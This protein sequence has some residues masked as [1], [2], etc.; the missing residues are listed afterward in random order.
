M[1]GRQAM[2]KKSLRRNL[3][4]GI[5]IV[6]VMTSGIAGYLA[7]DWA[8]DEAIEMQDSIL[9]HISAIVKT[10]QEESVVIT[11]L[12]GVDTDNH[13]ILVRQ[14][15]DGNEIA[16][17]SLWSLP[18]GLQDTTI[19]GTVYRAFLSEMASGSR[20]A[21]LQQIAVRDEIG[22]G[23]AIRTI[24]PILALIPLIIIMTAF[25]LSSSFKILVQLG[26]DLDSRS[27]DNLENLPLVSA[28]SELQ[29]FLTSLNRMFQRAHSSM[30]R[31]KK[32]IGDAAHELR[33]PITALSIQAENLD[34]VDLPA[35]TRQRVQ[36]VKAGAQ[37]TKHLL[38]QLLSMARQESGIALNKEIEIGEATKK[39]ISNLI[40]SA[41]RKEIDLGLEQSEPLVIRA[42][43]ISIEMLLRNVID[44][45]IKYTPKG[46][47]IDI[48]LSRIDEWAAISVTD[49]GPGIPE[50]EIDAVFSPFV[51]G[52]RNDADGAG[53]GL[54]IVQR[55][56]NQLNGRVQLQNRTS[57]EGLIVSIFLP[58]QP[59]PRA[60]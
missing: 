44:N 45:A 48:R 3:F 50:N 31:Q 1:D 43:V 33:T 47:Q 11:H 21:V 10:Q 9:M 28:P 54:S 40:E 22:T 27:A 36:A 38:E 39:V 7:Y 59:N 25:L 55:I 60:L 52:Q 12:Y 41:N 34:D 53:L 2:T 49:T 17:R 56:A 30:D 19:N 32:L 8:Y 16:F 6:V 13:A 37:R 24:A 35:D 42:E 4:R 57:R 58:V 18:P 5:A 20:F 29:P 46:G 14:G 15:K 26:Q 51:R 23:V